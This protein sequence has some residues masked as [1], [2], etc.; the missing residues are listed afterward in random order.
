MA[1]RYTT[2]AMLRAELEAALKTAGFPEPACS[3]VRYGTAD[4]D[5][6]VLKTSAFRY[7]SVRMPL[8]TLEGY[9]RVLRDMPGVIATHIVHEDQGTLRDQVQVTHLRMWDEP[10]A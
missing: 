7:A 8:E 1:Y 9:E 3:K 2:P 5:R 10:D 4:D 6:P